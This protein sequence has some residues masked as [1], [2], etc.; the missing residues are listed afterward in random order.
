MRGVGEA[1]WRSREFLLFTL[2][3]FLLFTSQH[4]EPL[5]TKRQQRSALHFTRALAILARHYGAVPDEK[6]RRSLICEKEERRS[7]TCDGGALFAIK[8]H[9]SSPR[10]VFAFKAHHLPP[11]HHWVPPA[12][13]LTGLP[14]LAPQWRRRRSCRRRREELHVIEGRARMRIHRDCW[15]RKRR[16]RGGRS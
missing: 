11:P 2:G 8:E 3:E 13:H 9:H 10:V 4:F 15:R 14:L 7:C 5:S 16:R 6:R 12:R 1:L